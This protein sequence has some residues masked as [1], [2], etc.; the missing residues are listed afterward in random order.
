[1]NRRSSDIQARIPHKVMKK[2]PNEKTTANMFKYWFCKNI[3]ILSSLLLAVYT[4]IHICIR[5]CILS[6]FRQQ[7]NHY[8][9]LISPTQKKFHSF[10]CILDGSIFFIM[11]L[12]DG[13]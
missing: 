13:C 10:I 3:Y 12:Q 4:H 6:Y 8:G 2:F 5:A 9:V 7:R 1:M 11:S